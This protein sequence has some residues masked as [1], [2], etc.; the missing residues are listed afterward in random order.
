MVS[1]CILRE[2]SVINNRIAGQMLEPLQ[3]CGHGQVKKIL[4]FKLRFVVVET[5]LGDG[6]ESFVK[7]THSTDDYH[8]LGAGQQ[9]QRHIQGSFGV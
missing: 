4:E 9:V 8:A 1:R 7:L 5:L 6:F 2:R 3:Q